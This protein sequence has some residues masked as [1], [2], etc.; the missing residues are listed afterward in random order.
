MIRHAVIWSMA[1]GKREDLEPLL[2]ELRALPA[3]IEEIRGLSAGPLLNESPY[4]AA[5]CVDVEDEAALERYRGHP[6]HAP[7]LA[8]LRAVAAEIV[9]GDYRF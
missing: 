1:P 5:L 8:R 3:A 6:A 9:V 7:S 4:H 2:E